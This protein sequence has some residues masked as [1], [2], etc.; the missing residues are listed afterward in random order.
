MWWWQMWT[1]TVIDYLAHLYGEIEIWIKSSSY[2]EGIYKLEFPDR[3]LKISVPLSTGL[4]KDQY[5][6]RNWG[7]LYLP[8]K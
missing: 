3:T 7:V 2:C 5:G 6:K 8:F 1:S 4:M